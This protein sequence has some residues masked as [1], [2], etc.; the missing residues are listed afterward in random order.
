[1]ILALPKGIHFPYLQSSLFPDGLFPSDL[2]P[3]LYLD[4]P[5]Y[6]MGLP[7]GPTY[8]A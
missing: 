4:G 5:T 2:I 7:N 8:I 6:L 3:F 1:M